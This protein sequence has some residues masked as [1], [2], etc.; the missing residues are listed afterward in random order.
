MKHLK[1]YENIREYNV[2]DY[3]K[4]IKVAS[5][6]H[7]IVQLVSTDNY[8]KF[9]VDVLN[10]KR[11]VVQHKNL[12]YSNIERLATQQEIDDIETLIE[13]ISKSDKY[14]L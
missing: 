7:D 5:E 3:V 1:S 10:I 12:T 2:G 6:Y 8:L 9:D 14:N 11:N 4:C 13:I